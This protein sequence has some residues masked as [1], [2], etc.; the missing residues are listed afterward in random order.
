MMHLD[1]FGRYTWV[2]VWK[3]LENADI[4]E[5]KFYVE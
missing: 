4:L 5:E 2:K 3:S 1:A